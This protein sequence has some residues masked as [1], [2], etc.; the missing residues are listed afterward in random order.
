GSGD[1]T[2]A[3]A[4]FWGPSGVVASGTNNVTLYVADSGNS[5]IRKISMA[6]TNWAT[7]TLAGSASAGSLDGAG[8]AARFSGPTGVAADHA[9]NLYVADTGN[10]TIR[11]FTTAGLV[12]TLAGLAGVAGSADGSG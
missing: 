7:V 10:D 12:S 5:T 8:A 4:R 2:N 11:K 9:G 6:G 3:N 1:G